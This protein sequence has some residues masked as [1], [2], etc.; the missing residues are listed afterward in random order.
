MFRQMDISTREHFDM[1]TFPHEDFS[2]RGSFG[3]GTFWHGEVSA[4]GHFG[5]VAQVPKCLCRNVHIALQ[6]AKI[7]M[8]RNVQVLKYPVP[9]CPWCLI[10]GMRKHAKNSMKQFNFSHKFKSF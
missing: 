6:G 10:F 5:T 2:A 1:G 4:H 3:T 8:C 7:S 9:K